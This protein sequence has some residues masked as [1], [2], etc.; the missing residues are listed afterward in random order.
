MSQEAVHFEMIDYS[1]TQQKRKKKEKK[2][3]NLQQTDLKEAM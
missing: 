2:K 3:S 1:Q